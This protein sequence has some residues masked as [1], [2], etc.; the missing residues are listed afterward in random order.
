MLYQQLTEFLKKQLPESYRKNLYSWIEK[1]SL[2]N[3]GGDITPTGIEVAHIR[4]SA[5]LLFN[6]FP[7]RK[8][9]AALVMAQIQTWLNEH[10]ELRCQLDFADC[11]FSLDIYDDDT[12]DLTFDIEFQE[13]ITAVIDPKGTLEIDGQRYK[14]DEI[15]ID[16]AEHFDLTTKK[17]S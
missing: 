8:L 1:G 15:H 6:E 3:Q 16:H 7:Y 12:A 11:D 10:D 5:T 4:Y 9:S 17:E 14:L 2:I 13:P